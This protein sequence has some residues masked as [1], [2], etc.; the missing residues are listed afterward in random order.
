ML[1][2]TRV[3]FHRRRTRENWKWK[4]NGR[5][6]Y[7]YTAIQLEVVFF[8][9]F[10]T[11]FFILSKLCVG[12][13]GIKCAQRTHP[14]SISNVSIAVFDE[15]E[16]IRLQLNTLFYVMHDGWCAF[17]LFTFA[18]YSISLL[19]IFLLLA[20]PVQLEQNIAYL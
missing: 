14:H 19:A 16:V 10:S 9:V 5:P 11:L 15:I 2:A 8:E 20:D 3:L 1:Y 4:M 7:T 12:P 6:T 17:E 18:F 13:Y